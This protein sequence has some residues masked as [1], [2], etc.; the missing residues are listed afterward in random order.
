[1]GPFPAGGRKRPPSPLD[2]PRRDERWVAGGR[3]GR[4]L[5]D[6]HRAVRLLGAVRADDPALDRLRPGRAGARTPRT[7]GSRGPPRQPYY[8]GRRRRATRDRV[9]TTRDPG[10]DDP[11]G[12]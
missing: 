7:L 9:A 4:G 12:S 2:A 6:L 11:R 3:A 10:G 5:S 8:R 1:A